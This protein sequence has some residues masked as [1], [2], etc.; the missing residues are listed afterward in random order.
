M[1]ARRAGNASHS[2]RD[3]THATSADRVEQGRLRGGLLCH[4]LRAHVRDSLQGGV[5]LLCGVASRLAKLGG[6]SL[7]RFRRSPATR[8]SLRW[9]GRG[10]AKAGACRETGANWRAGRPGRAAGGRWSKAGGLRMGVEP[11]WSRALLLRLRLLGLPC[12]ARRLL[13]GR[14]F[15]SRLR[16]SVKQATACCVHHMCMHLLSKLRVCCAYVVLVHTPGRRQPCRGL[17]R[18][19][20]RAACTA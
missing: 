6:G 18:A 1:R 2:E 17:R 3:S 9:V 4:H 16:D 5:L 10:G 8:L 7:R 11:R 14:R 19:R 15:Q 12:S 13:R 20:A